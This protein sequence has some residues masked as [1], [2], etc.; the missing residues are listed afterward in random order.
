MSVA[1]CIT[2]LVA[3]LDVIEFAT[4]RAR[5]LHCGEEGRVI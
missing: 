1:N 2:L 3:V 4:D 5:G